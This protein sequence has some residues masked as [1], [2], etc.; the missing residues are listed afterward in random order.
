MKFGKTLKRLR[1]LGW[2]SAYVDY[3]QLK[4]VIKRIEA[5]GRDEA[6]QALG[7]LTTCTA[8]QRSEFLAALLAE[9]RKAS[10]LY[11]EKID[12][13]E[14]ELAAIMQQITNHTAQ[15]QGALVHQPQPQL[16]TRNEAPETPQ[17]QHQH[18]ETSGE[19]TQRPP[20]HAQHRTAPQSDIV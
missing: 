6:G 2:S 19:T 13:W 10:K 3:K 20:I 15:P 9:A 12:K 4:R 11:D 16:A 5:A 14:K 17:P 18:E 7:S 8:Q 1:V